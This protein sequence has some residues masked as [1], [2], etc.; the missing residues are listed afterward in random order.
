MS[1]WKATCVCFQLFVELYGIQWQ[2]VS[3]CIFLNKCIHSNMTYRCPPK[4]SAHPPQAN[5]SISAPPPLLLT[6][7]IGIQGK[8]VSMPLY[9]QLF[10]LQ[11]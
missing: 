2:V 11:P 1:A 7:I 3:Y 6:P 8:P 5:S 10:K 4:I 9:L